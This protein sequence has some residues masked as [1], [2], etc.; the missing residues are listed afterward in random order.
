MMYAL[1]DVDNAYVSCERVFRPD[2]IGQ[3]VVVLS[4]NDGCVVARSNEA[5][6]MGIKA[7]VPYYQLKTLFPNTKIY[8]FSSNYELYADMTRRVM[9][10]VKRHAAEFHRYSIDEGFCVIDD[11]GADNLKTWGENLHR[12]ILKGTG[13]PVSIGIARTK[14]LAKMASWFAKRYKGF[15]HCCVVYDEQQRMKSLSL[16]PIDEVWG[17][18]HRWAAKLNAM[19]VVKAADFATMSES[20][21]KNFMNVNMWRTWLELNAVDAIA[22]E[23]MDHAKRKSICTSRSFP[24]M[25]TDYDEMAVH[26]A[27]YAALCAEKLR[28][29]HSVAAT[30]GVFV[31]TNHFR[32]DLPQ[33][34]MFKTIS[35]LTPSSSTQMIVET[36][37]RCLKMVYLQGFQYKRAGVVIM[38]ICGENEVQTSFIDYDSERYDKMKRLDKVTDRIK[39]TMGKG[40]IMLGAQQYERKDADKPLTFKD[41]VKRDMKSPNYTTCW[42][43]ILE[44]E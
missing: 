22:M 11:D 9:N 14:T 24:K 40:A 1:I 25:I 44:I 43:D 33:Y 12:E 42:Q 3:P 7:G 20:W 41:A 8:A 15:R 19:Q 30:I 39:R 32:E 6:A 26:V 16:F 21:V 4:N 37:N 5:K 28:K 27:N 29:Q 10:I 18:G 35:L 23:D 38:D 17:I 2:L 36:A 13:M 34:G 31:D